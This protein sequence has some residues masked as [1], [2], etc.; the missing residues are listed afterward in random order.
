MTRAQAVEAW[1]VSQGRQVVRVPCRL[2]WDLNHPPQAHVKTQ[3]GAPDAG[4]TVIT[5][6]T[7]AQA[8]QF[9]ADYPNAAMPCWRNPR[10]PW[11]R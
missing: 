9:M 7:M 3:H 10:A 1:E 2:Q 8:K 5:F 11:N 6:V 4:W